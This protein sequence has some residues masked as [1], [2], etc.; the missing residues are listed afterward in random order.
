[1]TILLRLCNVMFSR[2]ESRRRSIMLQ[3]FAYIYQDEILSSLEYKT[4]IT[5]KS[6]VILLNSAV[7]ILRKSFW[8]R[9]VEYILCRIIA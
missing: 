2:L 6:P 1:M 7:L 5:N 9:A 3:W 8:E 4:G